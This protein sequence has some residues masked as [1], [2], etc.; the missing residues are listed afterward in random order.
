MRKYGLEGF[1]CLTYMETKHQSNEHS[2]AGAN[3]FQGLIWIF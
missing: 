2:Q 3:D 1:F